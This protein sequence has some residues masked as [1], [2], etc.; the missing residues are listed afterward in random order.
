MV[1][2]AGEEEREHFVARAHSSLPRRAK[3]AQ[4]NLRGKNTQEEKTHTSV[5]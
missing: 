4:I 5:C 2:S 3:S 1:P